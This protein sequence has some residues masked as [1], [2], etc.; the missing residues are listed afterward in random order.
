MSSGKPPRTLEGL[1]SELESIAESTKQTFGSLNPTQLNWKPGVD[2][3]S[4]AQCLHHLL[5]A[6]ASYIPLFDRIVGGD[7]KNTFWENMPILP[8]VFGK[9]LI[10]S[11]EPSSTRKLT[12]PKAILPSTTEIDSQIVDRFLSQQTE[13]MEAFQSLEGLDLDRIKVTS[14]FLGL[15]T[16]SLRSA[17]TIIVV[18]EQRHV[19][20]AERVLSSQGFPVGS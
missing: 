12:A 13:L 4:V 1:T 15:I 2:R 7:K 19:Q 20:Q 11:L 14:P 6:N 10:K 17:C 16:Y 18:H 3:W 9:L 5:T 8:A